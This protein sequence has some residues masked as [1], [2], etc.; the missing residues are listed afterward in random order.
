MKG[1]RRKALAAGAVALPI[2]TAGVLTTLDWGGREG[3]TLKTTTALV[4][5]QSTSGEDTPLVA[6]G[7]TGH[8]EARRRAILFDS[9]DD[10]EAL[11]RE[12]LRAIDGERAVTVAETTD[13]SSSFLVVVQVVLPSIGLTLRLDRAVAHGEAVILDLTAGSSDGGGGAS[14]EELATL[15]VRCSQDGIST[16]DTVDVEYEGPGPEGSFEARS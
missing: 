15:F 13:F 4:E 1:T 8:G 2:V 7:L 9:E 5:Q 16:I 14:A 10:L 6:G 12:R 11:N 3:E